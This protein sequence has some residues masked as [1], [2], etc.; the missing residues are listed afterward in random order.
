MRTRNFLLTCLSLIIL[1][2]CAYVGKAAAPCNMDFYG[3]ELGAFPA[4]YDYWTKQNLVPVT[5]SQYETGGVIYFAGSFQKAGK[6]Q[7]K[8]GMS[9]ATFEQFNRDLGEGWRLDQ[10]NVL[11]TDKGQ[12]YAAIW[13]EDLKLAWENY[14]MMLQSEFDKR[15]AAMEEDSNM[16]DLR[17]L[18]RAD[19]PGRPTILGRSLVGRLAR[20]RFREEHGSRQYDPGGFQ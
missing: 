1:L 5:L 19:D 7:A 14:N 8:W 4:C 16:V 13:V 9:Q 10:L 18:P 20:D 11:T 12:F 3:I 15:F 17:V 6:R 2:T